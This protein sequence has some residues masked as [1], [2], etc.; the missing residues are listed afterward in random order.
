[1][2]LATV[3]TTG[4][5]TDGSAG[6]SPSTSSASMTSP[7]PGGSPTATG[8]GSIVGDV[9]RVARTASLSAASGHAEGTRSREERTLRIDVEGAA[10]G[11]NQTVFITSPGGGTSEVRTVGDGHWLGG[12]EAF[13][14]EQTGDPAAG[15]EMVGK[16]VA[17]SES[18][19]TELGS[20]TL[21]S[22][23]T[24]YFALPEVAALESDTSE[25]ARVDV[26]GRAAYLL[27]NAGGAQLWVAADGSGEILRAVG[28]PTAPS[29]MVF[30]EWGRAQ[31][32]S[33]PPASSVVEG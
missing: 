17:I 13:W 31:R 15:R 6:E 5:C 29:D 11:T 22:I 24:E 1:V 27:G 19:A 10:N 4:A 23:L 20:F 14:A 7:G 33:A 26:D 32:A 25:A 21:R 2:A 28:P 30:T 8:S 9:Y 12:D 3:S 16:Y 18:D